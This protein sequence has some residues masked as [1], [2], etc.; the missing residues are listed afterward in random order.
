M[1]EG[2]KSLHPLNLFYEIDLLTNEV[3][4][5]FEVIQANQDDISSFVT[6]SIND[7]KE[8]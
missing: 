8:E 6:R 2:S 5:I 1:K 7:Y 3:N 4:E